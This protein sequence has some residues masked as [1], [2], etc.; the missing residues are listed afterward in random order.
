MPRQFLIV[1][2]F[3]SLLR[4][5]SAEFDLAQLHLDKPC[6]SEHLYFGNPSDVQPLIRQGYVTE[7]NPTFRVPRWA[8]YHI[9]KEYVGPPGRDKASRFGKWRADPDVPNPV[10]GSE[11]NSLYKNGDGYARGHLAP[12][13]VMGGDRNGNNKKAS[14][15]NALTDAFDEKTIFDCMLMSNI[16]P[17]FHNRFNGV[18]GLWFAVERWE[19]D[20]LAKNGN[21]QVWVSAGCIFKDD[22]P[23][24]F[25]GTHNDIGVPTHFF[26]IV[27]YEKPG[28][29]LPRVFAFLF[30]HPPA[31]GKTMDQFL[32]SVRDI[33]KKTKLDFMKDLPKE[34]Q[35]KLEKKS[36]K[37]NWNKFQSEWSMSESSDGEDVE[38]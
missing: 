8:A 19:Q 33:E 9:I 30:P 4:L 21:Y 22:K 14:P 25:T 24:E 17:Q 37:S 38:D 3:T 2:L 15:D 12:Y 32:T 23:L 35:D 10:K 27:I 16:A 13:A 34:L 7:Y 11:Y 36:T 31:E 6:I 20:A 29:N 28:E 18:T 1:V 5:S 26:K